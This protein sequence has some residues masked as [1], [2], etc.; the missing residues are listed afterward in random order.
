MGWSKAG[1]GEGYDTWFIA[2]LFLGILSG[3]IPIMLGVL[4]VVILADILRK[5][6]RRRKRRRWLK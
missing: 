1:L 5:G 2:A 3:E 4:F 6:K